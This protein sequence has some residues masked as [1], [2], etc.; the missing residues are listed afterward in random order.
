MA[1]ITITADSA[2]QFETGAAEYNSS[3]RLDDNTFIVAYRD[4]NDGNK[5]KV[6]VGTRSGVTPTISES[7]AV[8]FNNDDTRYITVRSLSSAKFVIS[9]LDYN[10]S[11]RY[12]IVGTVSGSTITLGT[13]VQVYTGVGESTIS[14]AVLDSTNFVV[15][16]YADRTG[17]G[18]FGISHKVGS[19]SGTVISLGAKQEPGGATLGANATGLNV[20]SVGLDSTHFFIAFSNTTLRGGVISVDTGSQTV[21]LG[22]EVVLIGTSAIWIP[23][24][25]SF[26]SQH[27]VIAS[28]Q[29]FDN[30]VKVIAASINLTSLVTTP[31]NT[32]TSA[33]TAASNIGICAITAYNF[34][35]SYYTTTNT[36]GEVVSG[37]LTGSS[38][39]AFD[40]Q[41]AVIFDNSTSAY[42]SLCRMT[43]NYFLLSYKRG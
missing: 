13:A 33:N 29:N 41:G 43:D 36:E 26:D 5:G 14:V 6:N 9:Y 19:V 2:T 3:C 37:T 10:S 31:G 42:T 7:N 25:A 22:T 15:S 27:V 20:A 28:T 23:Q 30:T 35:L 34:I 4:T 21:T 40:A 39:L 11:L 1:G 12:V 38:T 24:V 32:L 18:N 8:V 16:F 17:F